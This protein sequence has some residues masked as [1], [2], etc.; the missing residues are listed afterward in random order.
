MNVINVKMQWKKWQVAATIVALALGILLVTQFN[1]ATLIAKGRSEIQERRNSLMGILE[2]MDNDN[3]SLEKEVARTKA[4]I[5]KYEEVAKGVVGAGLSDEIDRLRILTGYYPVKG[6]G[7][8]LTLDDHLVPNLSLDIFDLMDLV[9]ILR[10]GGAEAIAINGQRIVA[11]SEIYVSGNNI[12]VNKT[13]ISSGRNH[14]FVIDA[15]GNA[16][17]L[18][19]YL[20]V[21]DGK[22]AS[23]KENKIDVKILKQ[24]EVEIPAYSDTLKFRY[25]K[26]VLEK[27][28][29]AGVGA[30]GNVGSDSGA[31]RAIQPGTNPP[32]IQ[33]AAQGA[34]G[35][36]GGA[37][38]NAKATG[39]S[40][41]GAGAAGA[42]AAG[43]GIAGSS[44]TTT[45]GA[46]NGA[47][48]QRS[49]QP[50]G[51]SGNTGGNGG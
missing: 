33:P 20:Q 42:N 43:S 45:G 17:E 34:T 19:R 2:K 30:G 41:A 3:A 35:R 9:N 23:L 44:R 28:P 15:I 8:R 26:P 24:S 25:A 39:V 31:A 10:Y 36:T 22:I 29:P 12:L 46:A 48:G 51:A 18:S 21:T 14:V 27:T 38:G 11:N 37:T 47:T 7:I 32:A 40:G 5:A 1:T 49:N 50:S 13:P 4:E 16:D 6:P